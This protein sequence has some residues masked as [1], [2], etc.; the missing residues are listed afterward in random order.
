[1]TARPT[2]GNPTAGLPVTGHPSPGPVDP[3]LQAE[4]T[5][6]AWTR[7]S[8]GLIANG[9]LVLRSGVVGHDTPLIVAGALVIALAAAVALIGWRRHSRIDAATRRGASPVDLPTVRLVCAAA[10]LTALAAL[11]AAL[12]G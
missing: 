6:L 3:G 12:G 9:F 5:G 8:L 1:V 11:F 2:L 10:A 4:R 7:T